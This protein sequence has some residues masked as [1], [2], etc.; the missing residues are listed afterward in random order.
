MKPLARAQHFL[1]AIC[2]ATGAFF[3]ATL[4]ASDRP[5]SPVELRHIILHSQ[6]LGAH[7]LGYGEKSLHELAARI[8]PA[9]IPGLVD[10][11]S[12]RSLRVG[13]QFALASQCAEAIPAV[14]EAAIQHKMDFLAAQDTVDLIS[15]F[16]ACSPSAQQQAA[17]ARAAIAELQ[18][19]DQ[20]RIE[21][22]A[23]RRAEEDARIQ[24]NGLKLLDP[25]Q[26][27]TLTREEREE[28]YHRSLRAMGIDETAQLTPQQRQFVNRMYR[29]M[30]LGESGP[31]TPQ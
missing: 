31:Q 23:K 9:D 24:R 30:V 20:I 11:L 12:D 29:T 2:V 14:R 6:H 27:A 3:G 1:L 13:V 22:E 21:A 5:K 26:A 25:K 10:L 19:A 16:D 17:A 8:V 28:V 15:R 7:G 18:Q 4:S